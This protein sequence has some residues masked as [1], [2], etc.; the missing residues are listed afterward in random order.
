M[1]LPGIGE[2]TATRLA[3]YTMDMP[4]EDVE[5]FARALIQVKKDIHQCPICG[6]IMFT[7]S[8]QYPHTQYTWLT[9]AESE[10]EVNICC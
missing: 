10:E 4:Q 9:E 7:G 3:F 1:K 5:D 8:M 6:N 2:K